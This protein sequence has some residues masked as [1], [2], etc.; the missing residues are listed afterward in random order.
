MGP[1]ITADG[2]SPQF[3]RIKASGL[4]RCARRYLPSTF[5][6]ETCW[7]TATGEVLGTEFM[8]IGGSGNAL[9]RGV[10]GLHGQVLMRQELV[11]RFGYGK[12]V[13]WV[14]RIQDD[15]GEALPAIAG[16]QSCDD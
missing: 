11:L 6:L 16:P 10:Q 7:R 12:I 14:H 8:Q 15:A 5:I 13:R 9:I 1:E 2:K 3:T 4:A